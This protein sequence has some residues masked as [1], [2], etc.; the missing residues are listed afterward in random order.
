ME[1]A[2]H[3][4]NP[5]RLLAISLVAALVGAG[6]ATT[7]YA[8]TDSETTL[9]PRVVVVASS[10]ADSPAQPTQLSGTRP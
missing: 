4:P 2:L 9:H 7:T 8:L 1:R 3:Q 5:S 6:V 10:G